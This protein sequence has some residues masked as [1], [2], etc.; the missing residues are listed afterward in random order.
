MPLDVKKL[1]DNKVHDT[2]QDNPGVGN[3]GVDLER[4]AEKIVEKLVAEL[5]IENE[6]L[7][8]F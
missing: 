5:L 6:R 2:N 3:Q 7:G 1:L 4:L 8:R